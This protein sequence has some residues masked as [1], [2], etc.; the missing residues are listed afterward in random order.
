MNFSYR[1]EWSMEEATP[2]YAKPKAA[3]ISPAAL[4]YERIRNPRQSTAHAGELGISAE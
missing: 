1:P 4:I 3:V 2:D